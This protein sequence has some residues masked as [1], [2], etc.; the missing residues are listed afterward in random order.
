MSEA[1]NQ[2]P[3][4][5]NEL[6]FGSMP[7]LPNLSN[8]HTTDFNLEDFFSTDVPMPSSPPRMFHL[9]EDPMT[10]QNIDWNEFSNF[11]GR[12][13]NNDSNDTVIKKEPQE[14]PQKRGDGTEKEQV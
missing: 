13:P 2:S 3:S 14:S 9:Y 8:N 11:G 4:R 7:E 1:N 10:M 6:D 5:H 12:H